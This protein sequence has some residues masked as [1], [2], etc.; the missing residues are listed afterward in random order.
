MIEIQSQFGTLTIDHWKIGELNIN[1]D[2]QVAYVHVNFFAAADA[3]MPIHNQVFEVDYKSADPELKTLYES[4]QSIAQTR[5][6]AEL[7]A[8]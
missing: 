4:I 7:Q 6:A 2:S 1:F 5:I 8:Q 3:Q